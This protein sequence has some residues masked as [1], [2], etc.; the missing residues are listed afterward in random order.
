MPVDMLRQEAEN[1]KETA[2]P[3]ASNI[4]NAV[5]ANGGNKKSNAPKVLVV[6][7]VCTGKLPN[8][9]ELANK[10]NER[11]LRALKKANEKA[12]VEVEGEVEVEG[13]K[14]M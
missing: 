2:N 12:A 13:D 7:S 1:A 5:P 8:P 9:S 14:R 10:Q 11:Y 3:T 6:R 4:N